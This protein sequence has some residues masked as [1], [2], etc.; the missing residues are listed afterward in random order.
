VRLKPIASLLSIV[1]NLVFRMGRLARVFTACGV[2]L[3]PFAAGAQEPTRK[4]PIVRDAEAEQLLRDYAQPIFRAAGLNARAPEVILINE[5]TFNAFVA[6]GHRIFINVGALMEADTPNEIVGVLAHET[7]HI[8]GGHMARLR[9]QIGN[10]K[11]L[12]VA[13]MLLGAGAVAGAARSGD[14]VG[15]AGTGA[16][17]ALTG[18]QELIRRSLLSYQRS[19]ERAA[20]Q[21]AVRYLKATGQSPKGMLTTFRRFSDAAIFRSNALD[22][23][24]VSHP[25]PAERIAQLETLAK[26][27]PH[28]E[29]KDPPALQA[30]HDMVRAKLYGFVA[31]P[32]TVM[33]RYPARDTSAPARYARAI[34][35]YRSGRSAEALPDRRLDPEPAGQPLFPGVQGPGPARSRPRPRGDRAAAPRG[36]RLAGRG[37]DPG[38]A[39]P[40]ARGDERPQAPRRS[41]PRAFERDPARARDGRAVPAP[42]DRLRPQGQRADG[43][44][45]FGAG[46]HEQRRLEDGAYAGE[47][48]HGEAEAGLAALSQGR[49]HHECAPAR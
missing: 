41:H 14:R 37:A 45:R 24:L 13:G 3:A 20:D 34:V 10:A 40:C 44:A 7:G 26:H 4:L 49:R 9:E 19:E 42:R 23:Y 18:P 48:R 29:T 6:G 21:S 8:A 31:R 32:E 11:I 28:Y 46:L 39:R 12:S 43:G 36:R 33:R 2:A 15:N 47:P 38:H 35:A 22:P 25:L 1:S 5:Q 16:M 27:S 17:G 30:R